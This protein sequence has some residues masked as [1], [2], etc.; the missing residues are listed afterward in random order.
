MT[1]WDGI[2]R[3]AREQAERVVEDRLKAVRMLTDARRRTAELRDQLAAAE[4]DDRR[5]WQDALRQGW[6]RAELR[7]SGLSEPA[8]K[9]TRRKASAVKKSAPKRQAPPPLAEA[10]E[11]IERGVADVDGER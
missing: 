2:E 9:A 6:T 3:R 11:T 4:A 8:G 10:I 7:A 1:D 5:L